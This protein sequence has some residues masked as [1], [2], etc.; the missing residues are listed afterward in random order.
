MQKE[1]KSTLKIH[2]QIRPQETPPEP[3]QTPPTTQEQQTKPEGKMKPKPQERRERE[4]HRR[5]TREQ[6]ERLSAG[7]RL[8]RNSAVACALLLTVMAMKNVDQ[9]WSRQAVEGIRQ[10]M[11]M[12]VDWDETLGK[13]SFVRSI[14][15]ETALVF[16]NLS[17]RDVLN[18]PV[19]GEISHAYT[20]Q[21]PWIE[22]RC[23]SD[24]SVGAALGGRVSAV[25]EGMS[26]DWIVLIEDE[27][28]RE[29]VYGYMADVYVRTG[30]E[31][32]AGQIIGVTS[33]EEASRLYFELREGGVSVDPSDKIR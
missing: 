18:A 21:Q 28:G 32:S 4:K 24:T 30:D 1:S 33:Q 14:V 6:G 10:A 8:V 13:L 7:E 15:P 16:F 29:T 23:A 22:Y 20:E 12:R 9:P 11:T 2:T 19:K 31:V 3:E 17:P 27:D 26:G 5:R 25:G